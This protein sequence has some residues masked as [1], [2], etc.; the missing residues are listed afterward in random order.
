MRN[1]KKES[2]PTFKKGDDTDRDM[3]WSSSSD[4]DDQFDLKD[5]CGASRVMDAQNVIDVMA[6]AV[7]F[8]ILVLQAATLNNMIDVKTVSIKGAYK[9]QMYFTAPATSFDV[10]SY[11]LT[12]VTCVLICVSN[13]CAFKVASFDIDHNKVLTRQL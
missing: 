13:W 3:E 2:L 11:W 4:S 10:I 7:S 5:H 1:V 8:V 6:G 12:G 9:R